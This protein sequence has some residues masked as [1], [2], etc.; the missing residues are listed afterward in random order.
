MRASSV[1]ARPLRARHHVSNALLFGAL[2]LAPAALHAQPATPATPPAAQPATQTAAQPA[3]PPAESAQSNPPTV[4]P[5]GD[6]TATQLTSPA[7]DGASAPALTPAQRQALGHYERGRGH[8][9][10]G[11]YRFAAAELEAAFSIDPQG[12]N[13]LYNL[14]TVYERLGDIPRAI[15]AYQR[16]LDAQT[17]PTERARIVRVLTRL[18][19]ARNEFYALRRE[20]GRADGLF[21]LTTGAAIASAGVGFAWLLTDPQGDSIRPVIGFTVGGAALGALAAILYFSR[22]APPRSILYPSVIASRQELAL[23]LAG[24]F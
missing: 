12:T 5:E 2:A 6:A 19:G 23:G 4:P 10:A 3:T 17:D 14:G 11:R 7:I 18:G 13:L 1:G 24:S 16:Y 21:F 20:R 9:A 8:Y 15:M 22:D